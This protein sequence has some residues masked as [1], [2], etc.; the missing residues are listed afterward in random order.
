MGIA[1]APVAADGLVPVF[2]A[3]LSLA[4]NLLGQ[5]RMPCLAGIFP[6]VG[7]AKT[8]A[9]VAHQK[10][11][12]GIPVKMGLGEIAVSQSNTEKSLVLPFAL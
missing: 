6:R 7:I 11:P 10:Q 9:R 2:G 8:D 12:V 4:D 3:G 5:S 1:G